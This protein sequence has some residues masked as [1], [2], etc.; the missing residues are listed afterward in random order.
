MLRVESVLRV[1]KRRDVLASVTVLHGTDADV[2]GSDLFA[3]QA[4]QVG[5]W[6]KV[7]LAHGGPH[8]AGRRAIGFE[9]VSGDNEL[10]VGMV[11]LSASGAA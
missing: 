9:R 3:A 8:Q 7:S 4:P 11:L 6:R 1:P 5:I 2:D 10:A